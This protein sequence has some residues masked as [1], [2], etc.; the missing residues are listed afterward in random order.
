MRIWVRKFSEMDYGLSRRLKVRRAFTLIELL[1]VVAI[2]ALLLSISVPTLVVVREKASVIAG[3]VNQRGTAT[4]LN[5]F[6]N[7]NGGHC[8]PGT[9]FEDVGADRG[10]AADGPGSGRG[11]LPAALV[12]SATRD[13]R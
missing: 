7:D 2:I 5:L 3:I 10:V 12:G 6:A 4:S 9:C 8:S 1:V 11:Q 13:A